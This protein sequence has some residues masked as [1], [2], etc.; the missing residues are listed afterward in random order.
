MTCLGGGMSFKKTEEQGKALDDAILENFIDQEG[1]KLPSL[2]KLA[3][4]VHEVQTL[5]HQR[6]RELKLDH[7]YG[8]VS[9]ALCVWTAI[10]AMMEAD[11]LAR[12]RLGQNK[13]ED[14][15]AAIH[16]A[17]SLTG[18]LKQMV[19]DTYET[20]RQDMTQAFVDAAKEKWGKKA[21]E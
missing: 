4:I 11:V 1:R 2:V 12:I 8:P 13:D 5:I 15:K 6:C 20:A 7:N 16:I 9:V 19:A 3:P 10:C 21:D 14:S 17:E 18:G